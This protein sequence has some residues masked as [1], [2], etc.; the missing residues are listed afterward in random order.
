MQK[1]YKM[2][3]MLIKG[4]ADETLKNKENLTPWQVLLDDD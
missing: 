1:N 4:G 2:A 3:D